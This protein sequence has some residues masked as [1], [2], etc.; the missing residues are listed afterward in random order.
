MLQNDPLHHSVPKDGTT[1]PPIADN[2][3]SP[4]PLSHMAV[5]V[6]KSSLER[7]QLRRSAYRG[8]PLRIHIDGEAHGLL[9]LE[10]GV[11]KSFTVPLSATYVEIF[12]DDRAGGLLLGVLL[13][14][15]PALGEDDQPQHLSVT[16]EGGQT[17][18][19]EIAV[20]C[21]TGAPVREY[22]IQ[23]SYADA[24]EVDTGGAATPAGEILPV[25]LQPELVTP[26]N[27]GRGAI[28]LYRPGQ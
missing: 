21:G 16:L 12:G 22:V 5:A 10:G 28:Q 1:T 13:F 26:G 11:Y 15:E 8:G 17:V 9:A 3:F 7:N 23:V 19:M 24:A 25:V 14:P 20:G 27:P 18:T 4:T 6:V 2:R